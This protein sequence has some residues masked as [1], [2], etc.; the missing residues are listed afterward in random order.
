VRR[1][2]IAVIILATAVVTA[3]I[4]IAGFWLWFGSVCTPEMTLVQLCSGIRVAI[5]EKPDASGRLYNLGRDRFLLVLTAR[6]E[7]HPEGYFLD[8]FHGRVGLPDFPDYVPLLKYALVDR[9]IYDGFPELGTLKA[10]WDVK[11]NGKEI[12][13]SITGFATEEPGV[14]SDELLRDNMPIGYRNE[15]ILTK[16]E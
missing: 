11:R 9:R 4:L 5:P 14:D 10:E 3:I 15:I 13:L 6:S 12:H 8:L 16:N 1:I 7:E 2:K